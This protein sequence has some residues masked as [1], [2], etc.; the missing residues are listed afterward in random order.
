MKLSAN[1]YTK[2]LSISIFCTSQLILCKDTYYFLF[3]KAKK[4]EV[5][6][7]FRVFISILYSLRFNFVR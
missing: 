1:M 5:S 7:N 6:N 3:S 2:D 4:Q